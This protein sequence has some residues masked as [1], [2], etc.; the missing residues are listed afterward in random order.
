MSNIEL[1]HVAVDDTRGPG[2]Y[3]VVVEE[4]D[5]RTFHWQF[6]ERRDAE[7]KAAAELERLNDKFLSLNDCVMQS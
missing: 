1:F 5:C 2:K 6:F 3:V 7:R 4:R